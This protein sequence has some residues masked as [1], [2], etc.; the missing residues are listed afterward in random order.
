MDNHEHPK[1][2]SEIL[3]PQGALLLFDSLNQKQLEVIEAIANKRGVSVDIL[4]NSVEFYAEEHKGP[5]LNELLVMLNNP[6]NDTDI[7][8]EKIHELLD[9]VA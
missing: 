1:Q 9:L 5:R 2:T 3:T 7:Y 4:R 8:Q 6:G